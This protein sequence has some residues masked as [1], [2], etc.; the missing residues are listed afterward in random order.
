MTKHLEPLLWLSDARGV[1]IPRDFATSFVDRGKVVSGV[2]MTYWQTLENG[3]DDE[4]YWE[5]WA[6]V[7]DTA[8][9]SDGKTTFT[10]HQDGDLWL[11][12][13]GMV[14][15][16]DNDFFVWPDAVEPNGAMQEPRTAAGCLD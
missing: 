11:I 1:Y 10:L 12:P 7:L 3:P 9:V 15:S 4:Q 16:E 14:W 8:I 5:T 13:E 6:R 2:P